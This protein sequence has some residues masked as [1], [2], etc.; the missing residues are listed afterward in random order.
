VTPIRRLGRIIDMST[1][2]IPTHFD[3][4]QRECVALFQDCKRWSDAFEFRIGD[5]ICRDL[6]AVVE[7]LSTIRSSALDYCLV[8]LEAEKRLADEE[9]ER[10]RDWDPSA[11]VNQARLDEASAALAHRE[12]PAGRQE[13]IIRLLTSIDARLSGGAR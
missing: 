6:P 8:G 11:S 1:H 12:S 10:L 2:P 3:P 7:A 5:R 4:R 13:E 9:R